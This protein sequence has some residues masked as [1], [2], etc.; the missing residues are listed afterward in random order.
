MAS[1]QPHS[2]YPTGYH[3]LQALNLRE[4]GGNYGLAASSGCKRYRINA[5]EAVVWRLATEGVSNHDMIDRLMPAYPDVIN[6]HLDVERALER[7]EELELLASRQLDGPRFGMIFRTSY[8]PDTGIRSNKAERLVAYCLGRYANAPLP[9]CSAELDYTLARAGKMSLVVLCDVRN[10]TVGLWRKVSP[11]SSVDKTLDQ[12]Q[13]I[14]AWLRQRAILPPSLRCWLTWGDHAGC[15]TD[16]NQGIHIGM[17][18]EKRFDHVVLVPGSN[19]NRFLGPLLAEQFGEMKKLW[20]PWEQKRDC[21]WWGGDATG[22]TTTEWLSRFKFLSH[23]TRHPSDD[24]VVHPVSYRQRWP[25]TD[26]PPPKGRFE[27][28]DAFRHKCLVLLSGNDVPSGLSWYFCGNSVVMMEYPP[29][30][31]HILLFELE[32]WRHYVP[33]EADPGDV[34]VKLRWVMHN[35]DEAKAI[36]R[37]AHEHLRWM[38]GP[39]YIWACNEVIR[40]VATATRSAG[41]ESGA[42]TI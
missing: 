27:K 16:E 19:R 20:T 9:R 18:R 3:D 37:R 21:A 4:S 29:R 40:R 41:P 10:G 25:D 13:V 26:L 5:F 12:K 35:Q 23:F 28:R 38:S 2:V 15:M 11:A 22:Q 32:P 7:F 1:R 24:V 6:L 36:V 17:V 42:I 30:H 8:R 14:D 34:L 31:D 39:E 33:L